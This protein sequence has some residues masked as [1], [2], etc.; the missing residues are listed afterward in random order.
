MTVRCGPDTFRP[1]APSV[2]SLPPPTRL[3][4]WLHRYGI[5][6]RK[7]QP[8][9][10]KTPKPSSIDAHDAWIVDA[11]DG[12][13][14]LLIQLIPDFFV[15]NSGSSAL[16]VPPAIVPKRLLELSEGKIIES[17]G[18]VS[19]S[20]MGAYL[21]RYFRPYTDYRALYPWLPQLLTTASGFRSVEIGDFEFPTGVYNLETQNDRQV[22]ERF[23]SSAR[24]TLFKRHKAPLLE[25]N[26]PDLPIPAP[27]EELTTRFKKRLHRFE[28][29]QRAYRRFDTAR[30]AWERER[31]KAEALIRNPRVDLARKRRHQKLPGV[32]RISVLGIPFNADVFPSNL[33]ISQIAP[34]VEPYLSPIRQIERT[35]GSS[36]I[37]QPILSWF[38]FLIGMALIPN[39]R[40]WRL[41]WGTAVIEDLLP[42]ELDTLDMVHRWVERQMMDVVLDAAEEA[43]QA[44]GFANLITDRFRTAEQ[45]LLEAVCKVSLQFLNDLRAQNVDMLR[46]AV[47]EQGGG[48]IRLEPETFTNGHPWRL[49]VNLSDADPLEQ[50][51][52]EQI[53]YASGLDVDA[54]WM[55]RAV[56]PQ[57]RGV[58]ALCNQSGV[59][60]RINAANNR[61]GGKHPPHSSHK[62]GCDIDWDLGFGD[63]WVPNLIRREGRT[64]RPFSRFF[65]NEPLDDRDKKP[66]CQ[67]GIDRLLMWIGIQANLI[68]GVRALLYG[69]EPLMEDATRHLLSL[70]TVSRPAHSTTDPE[71]RIH[72]NHL[73]A[74][75]LPH[76]I[77]ACAGPLVWAVADTDDLAARLHTLAVQRDAD[78]NFWYKL[79]GIDQVPTATGDFLALRH[80]YRSLP[81]KQIDRQIRSWQSWWTERQAIGPALLPVWNPALALETRDALVCGIGRV[82]PNEIPA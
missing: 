5:D 6:W 57:V 26:D 60:L 3:I 28:E 47:E 35:F 29:S 52:P 65:R 77:Q 15:I 74:D 38:Y 58:T 41:H 51:F 39:W 21:V 64:N 53:K 25:P 17:K 54:H 1:A 81:G 68:A 24:P 46:F 48:R 67:V 43:R 4:K 23:Q 71:P 8:T 66:P 44:D 12:Y 11:W 34:F 73:H 55:L 80:V 63:D 37:A 18:S 75:Y 40:H 61:W 33:F 62:Q 9:R 49:K 72:Y 32:R 31:T 30:K 13:I 42:A 36:Y 7:E 50:S 69:D 82:V 79:A 27:G 78:T 16:S 45:S 19:R 2:A 76:A 56:W 22:L 20:A 14:K 10:T 59:K 70:F